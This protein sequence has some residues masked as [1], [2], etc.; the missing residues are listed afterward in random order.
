MPSGMSRRHLMINALAVSVL[1]PE[2][3]CLAKG[4]PAQDLKPLDAKDSSASALGY[5]P[6]AAAAASNPVY[7]KGQHCATCLHYLG[8]PSDATDACNI[9]A[10]HSV[11]ENGWCIVW[12]VR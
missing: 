1:V 7:K 8:Q 2:L 10:G 5:V 12:S 3:T 6:D 4:S 9:Y 11:P